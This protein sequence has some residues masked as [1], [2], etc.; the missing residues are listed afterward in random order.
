MSDLNTVHAG[1]KG[2]KTRLFN[3]WKDMRKRCSNKNGKN[4]KNYIDRGISICQE[5]NDF[6]IFRTWSEAHGYT[7]ELTIERNDVNGNYEPANCRWIPKS[8][9]ARNKTNTQRINVVGKIMTA[10]EAERA[11]GLSHAM[12]NAT[13]NHYKITHQEAFDLLFSRK[14]MKAFEP[15]KMAA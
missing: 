7:D 10:A 6:A 15:K 4:A 5:W 14:I 1:S 8:E 3:I 11:I 13:R 2:G 12:I 9:Q